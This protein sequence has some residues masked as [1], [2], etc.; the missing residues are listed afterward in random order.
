M[1]PD[2]LTKSNNFLQNY[3]RYL[4]SSDV[5]TLLL[6]QIHQNEGYKLEEVPQT[7]GVVPRIKAQIS[8]LLLRRQ[9]TEI[10]GPYPEIF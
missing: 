4:E 5:S 10:S 2:S 7:L 8:R 1:I 6:Q 3:I 9:V